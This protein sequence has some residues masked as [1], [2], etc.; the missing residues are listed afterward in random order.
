MYNQ[1][2]LIILIKLFSDIIISISALCGLAHIIILYV[3]HNVDISSML[4]NNKF[5]SDILYVYF[6]HIYK[7]YL[8]RFITSSRRLYFLN[9]C[10]SECNNKSLY[11]KDKSLKSSNQ[12]L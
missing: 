2:I 5:I 11:C 4:D 6:I 7:V 3:Q 12:H 10:I 8:D 9:I 1:I